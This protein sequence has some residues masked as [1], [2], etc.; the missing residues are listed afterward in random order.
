VE[1]KDYGRV[2]EV[3]G[4]AEDLITIE[5]IKCRIQFQEGSKN[6][7]SVAFKISALIS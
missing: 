7:E 6:R 5:D 3:P 2:D 4:D 1:A